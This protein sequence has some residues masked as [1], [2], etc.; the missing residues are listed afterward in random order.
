ME[1]TNDVILQGGIVHI[2]ATDKIAIVTLSVGGTKKV[3]YPKVLFFGDNIK[4]VTE[5]YKVGSKVCVRGNIQS[6]RYD[7]SIKNQKTVSIFGE[8]I[9]PANSVIQKTFGVKGDSAYRPQE[10]S[11]KLAGKVVRIEA[12]QDMIKM[13]VMTRKNNRVSFIPVAFYTKR[14][15]KMLEKIHVDDQVFAVGTTQTSKKKFG[16]E[17]RYY[18]DYVATDIAT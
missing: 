6:S 1:F 16:D 14:P 12:L 4:E 15:E 7:P 11:F 5:N 18:E 3:N 17:V 2:F 8:S 13:V 9:E 10:N